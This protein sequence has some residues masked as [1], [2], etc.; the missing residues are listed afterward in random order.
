MRGQNW[1]PGQCVFCAFRRTIARPTQ[2][3]R[4]CRAAS[5]SLFSTSLSR[6]RE[7]SRRSLVRRF[8]DLGPRSPPQDRSSQS[9]YLPARKAPLVEVSYRLDARL[10]AFEA[11]LEEWPLL[12]GLGLDADSVRRPF[13]HF[14]RSLHL[15]IEDDN[16]RDQPSQGAD[17]TSVSSH[18][19]A[20]LLANL[21]NSRP[22]P[23]VEEKLKYAFFNFLS[24][25]RSK[26]VIQNQKEIA[27][28]RNPTEWFPLARTMRRKVHLH[29][30]P[31]NSGKTYH[32]LKRLEESPNGLYA[33]PLRLLAQEVHQ[34]M[35]AKGIP[36]QLRTGEEIRYPDDDIDCLLASCTVEMVSMNRVMSVAVI[37][38]MQMISDPARGWAWT[39]AFLGVPAE[40]VHLCGEARVL[41]LVTELAATTGDELIVHRYERLSPLEM[42]DE[43][44]RGNLERLR[45]GDC[46]VSFSVLSIHALRREVEHVTGKK[47]AIIYGSLPPETRQQQARL[48]NDPNNEYDILI[49]SDA[50]GMGLNLSI[51]R[52]ILESTIKFDGFNRVPLKVSN[53]KQIA[54]R[55]GRYRTA[56]QASTS[57]ADPLKE[58]YGPS[59]NAGAIQS[60]GKQQSGG[61]VTTLDEIDFRVVATAMTMEPEPIKQ[62]GL[63]P[64][65]S[66]ISRFA[67]YFPPRTPLSYILQ[68][69]LDMSQTHQRYKMFHPHDMIEA[70]D[71]IHSVENLTIA[72][73]LVFMV[74]PFSPRHPTMPKL[75]KELAECVANQRGGSVLEIKNMDLDILDNP[76]PSTRDDLR[77]L[78]YLHKSLILYLWLSYR[79]L[80]IFT[81]RPLAFHV[82]GLCEQAIEKCIQRL[83]VLKRQ[84][85]FADLDKHS[86]IQK[87]A[88]RKMLM[89]QPGHLE[90]DETD[91]GQA[92]SSERGHG[93]KDIEVVSVLNDAGEGDDSP[94]DGVSGTTDDAGEYPTP[95]VEDDGNNEDVE[96]DVFVKETHNEIVQHESAW[97]NPAVDAETERPMEQAVQ[98]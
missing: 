56:D 23:V 49:A 91:V 71:T 32:A 41:P 31:T 68:R 92:F 65:D 52:I 1:T 2:P 46:I 45:K 58:K 24:N 53:I 34:R 98:R 82:K 38:E 47:V 25:Q 22:S 97:V 43:S 4:F 18:G 33:G 77:A 30:G 83:S 15:A 94:I 28:M 90:G 12:E 39:Q 11:Q 19:L 42:E 13:A 37:D 55:A 59:A 69:F 81:T 14:R 70:L 21:P 20:K 54:G 63:A 76:F 73:R 9:R 35:N 10:D 8:D 27:N 66:I 36:C 75:L 16:S 50:I 60:A 87:R 96:K 26:T 17:Y 5:V 61:L 64:P 79:F 86:T 6:K 93:E 88:V 7:R 57:N 89:S 80:G 44:L 74:A 40:E 62:A 85:L 29:I 78:E 95:E 3:S 67:A 51:K 72:D 48:F 84:N